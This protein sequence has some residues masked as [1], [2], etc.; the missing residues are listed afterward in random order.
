MYKEY[1]LTRFNHQ[2]NTA[3]LGSVGLRVY[4]SG[5][6]FNKGLG[7]IQGIF[8]LILENQMEHEL[9]NEREI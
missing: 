4:G 8:P 3:H 6:G 7:T 1:N 5:L 9:G 2:K